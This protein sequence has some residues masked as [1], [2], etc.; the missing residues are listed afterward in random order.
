MIF[1][2]IHCHPYWLCRK[3]D[4]NNRFVN[5]LL[6]IRHIREVSNGSIDHIAFGTDMDGLTSVPPDLS[7]SDKIPT[8]L[9]DQLRREKYN[10]GTPITE[11]DIQKMSFENYNRVLK[12]GW[13]PQG[14][15]LIA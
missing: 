9:L 8:M 7:S 14:T 5:I 3:V 10:D 15:N 4:N 2:D 11:N 1:I 6:T 12:L 13:G